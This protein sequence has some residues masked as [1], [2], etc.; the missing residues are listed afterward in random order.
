MA[1]ITPIDGANTSQNA[2]ADMN[3]RTMSR[4][5]RSSLRVVAV[6]ASIIVQPPL[7]VIRPKAEQVVHHPQKHHDVNR[8]E[9]LGNDAV[10]FLDSRELV[11]ADLGFVFAFLTHGEPSL[12]GTTAP[13]KFFS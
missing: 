13:V 4:S 6:R 1:K 8:R 9:P 12:A 3:L 10:T 11:A 7:T 2:A 5:T